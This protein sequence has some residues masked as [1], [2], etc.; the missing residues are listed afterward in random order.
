[1]ILTILFS[2]SLAINGVL[3][4]YSK[5]LVTRLKY[6]INN[7]DELQNLL[8]EYALSLE[9]MLDMEIYYGDETIKAAVGNTKMVIE[10]CKVYKNSIIETDQYDTKQ[11]SE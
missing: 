11:Q 3:F 6:G 4:W 9:A 2:L 5:Q 1:M 10:T 7:V 8:N